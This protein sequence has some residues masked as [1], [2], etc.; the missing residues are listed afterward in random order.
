[1][2]KVLASGRFNIIHPGHV[3]YLEKAKSLGDFLVVVI[4]SDRTVK[5]RGKQLLF[6]A[7]ERKSLVKALSCVNKAVIGYGIKSKQGYIK[8][9]KKEKPSIIAL[10]YDNEVSIKEAKALAKKAGLSCKVVRIKKYKGFE[11]KKIIK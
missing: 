3:K 6:P 7:K 10:G 1:M 8:I 9:L 4:A 5:N 11:T 2:K